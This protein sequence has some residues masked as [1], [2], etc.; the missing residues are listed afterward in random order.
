MLMQSPLVMMC[1]PGQVRRTCTAR[2][3]K[4]SSV[5]LCKSLARQTMLGAQLLAGLTAQADCA[6]NLHAETVLRWCRVQFTVVQWVAPA[7]A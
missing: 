2:K 4:G 1:V 3:H 7:W 6:L 5:R